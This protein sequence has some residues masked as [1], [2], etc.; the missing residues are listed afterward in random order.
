MA[1]KFYQFDY[2]EM[3]GHQIV[4]L[5]IL[6]IETEKL[7]TRDMLKEFTKEHLHN[8]SANILIS[9]VIKLSKRDF[10]KIQSAKQDT[11]E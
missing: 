10:E 1:Q 6:C 4:N 7:V 5:G 8:P 3:E 9:N 11:K 2:A